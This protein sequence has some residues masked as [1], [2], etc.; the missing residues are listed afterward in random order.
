MIPYALWQ[1][2][3][4]VHLSHSQRL[5]H[6]LEER[7]LLLKACGAV[8]GEHAWIGRDANPRRTCTRKGRK[9]SA[10]AR[11]SLPVAEAQGR[12]PWLSVGPAMSMSH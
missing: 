9:R 10:G 7:H 1:P 11:V 12:V 3:G 6:F 8:D 2:T 5:L 4:D